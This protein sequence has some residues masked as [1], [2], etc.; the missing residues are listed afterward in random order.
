MNVPVFVDTNVLVY[1]R[2]AADAAKQARAAAWLEILWREQA[3]RTS[4]QVLSEYYVTLTRK[5]DPGLPSAEAW[6]DV[7]ALFTWR[8]QAIDEAVMQRGREIEQRH[9]L[10]WWDSLIIAAAAT[11]GCALLLSE[12]LQDGGVYAGVTVRSP[13]TL[14]V[15]EPAATYAMAPAAARGHPRRGRPKRGVRNGLYG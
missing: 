2:D 14:A 9:R 5:L 6:D 4:I 13:F 7:S 12:D 3:G 8:P 1:A 11:Q 10:G 15:D